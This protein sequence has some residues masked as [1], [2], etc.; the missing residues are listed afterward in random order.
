MPDRLYHYLQRPGSIMSNQN[1]ERN[2]EILE[3]FDD[4]LGWYQAQGLQERYAKELCA[5]TVE[6]VLL[7]ASVRVARAD[8]RHPLLE[9]FRAYTDKTFPEWEHNSYLRT[10]PKPKTLALWLIKGR[11]Y[12]T[13]SQLFR[14]KG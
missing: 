8:P 5:L 1:L 6:H 4:L 12:K 11:H 13:L 3:A 7:A 10:L 14:L 9:A 2:R